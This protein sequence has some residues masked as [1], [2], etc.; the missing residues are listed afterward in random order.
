MKLISSAQNQEDVMLWRALRQVRGGFYIDVGAAD[1]TDLSVTKIF[2]EQGWRGINLEPSPAYFTALS[3][4]RPRDINLRIG[5]GR[6]TG[7]RTFYNVA[8]TGLSTF[9]QQLAADH[10][11]HGWEV[12][13]EI[14]ETLTLAEI[15][16][17]HRPQGPIHFLKIDVE[18]TER[19][20]LAGA[21]FAAFRPWIVLVE[22]TRPLSQEESY[23]EWEPIL[24]RQGYSFVWFDG[25]NRFYLADE[26]KPE[27]DECFRVQPN[28]FDDFVSVPELTQRV[29]QAEHDLQAARAE[30]AQAART[31]TE[32]SHQAAN[33]VRQMAATLAE[34]LQVATDTQR[35]N[36]ELGR[37]LAEIHAQYTAL[38]S[39]HAHV[40]L[41]LSETERQRDDCLAS[42]ATARDA[43][44]QAEELLART[45]RSTSWRV[46]APLRLV[47]RLLRRGSYGPNAAE[48]RGDPV[49]APTQSVEPAA[50]ETPDSPPPPLPD[51]PPAP[52]PDL[53][54]EEARVLRQLAIDGVAAATAA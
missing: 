10:R 8:N 44:R 32:A 35:Q 18:G 25:L 46:T 37:Q 48:Q 47:R 49:S 38:S 2:Y 31:A 26:M 19:D 20:V 14:A 16:R 22:S 45:R 7:A 33:T 36:N 13:E 39:A 3:R 15:C 41:A 24:T 53:S 6:E 54:E 28:I 42:L 27:L 52:L 30:A 9:D 34:Q 40:Q 4:A 12:T 43:A 11:C 29:R 17:R 51:S 23:A 21:D 50:E 1:P 5:A